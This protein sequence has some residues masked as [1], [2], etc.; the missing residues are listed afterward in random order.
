MTVTSN[1]AASWAHAREPQSPSSSLDQRQN[2]MVRR[3]SILESDSAVSRII[4][5]PAELS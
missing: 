5:V 2:T 1:S 3:V 4:E